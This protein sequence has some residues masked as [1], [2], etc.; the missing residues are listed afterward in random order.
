MRDPTITEINENLKF[1]DPHKTVSSVGPQ[2]LIDGNTFYDVRVI[3]QSQS[4][5]DCYYEF[6]GVHPIFNNRIYISSYCDITD[7]FSLIGL[8]YSP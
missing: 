5:T 6:H 8:R 1:F 2:I 3:D 4:V 7:T